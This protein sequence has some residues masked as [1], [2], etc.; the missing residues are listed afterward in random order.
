MEGQS[1]EYL[2]AEQVGGEVGRKVGGKG[3]GMNSNGEVG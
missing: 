1:L 2:L 3:V